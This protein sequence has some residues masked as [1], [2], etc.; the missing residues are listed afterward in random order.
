MSYIALPNPRKIVLSGVF[1][2]LFALSA[3]QNTVRIQPST[4]PGQSASLSASEQRAAFTQFPDIPIPQGAQI[5][6][7]KTL[8]FGSN[9][10]IG[11]LTI[12]TAS[13]VGTMFDFYQQG[14]ATYNWQELTSVRALTSN[15]THT[16][17]DRVLI[18]SIQADSFGSSVITITA[19]P[20]KSLMATPV[21]KPAVPPSPAVT[22]GEELMPPG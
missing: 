15:M 3:C 18:V 4:S 11:Q 1:C 22:R 13:S 20:R 14:L 19:S 21:T 7:D 8:V 16:R 17:G 6:V 12:N 5:V 2:S 9:P 10:W